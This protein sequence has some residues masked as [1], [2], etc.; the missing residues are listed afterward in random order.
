M[1]K[2]LRHGMLQHLLHAERALQ[3]MRGCHLYLTRR[4]TSSDKVLL[5]PCKLDHFAMGLVPGEERP[6][7]MRGQG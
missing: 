6:Q 1:A 3:R 4:N 5:H 7:L 2:I